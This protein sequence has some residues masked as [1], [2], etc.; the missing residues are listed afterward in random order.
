MPTFK[1]AP[2]KYVQM[3]DHLRD[4]ITRG[5]L[6][7]GDEV[8]SE[9]Q[10]A[11]EWE[12]ARPTATKALDVLRR[13]GLLTGRQ[14]AGTFVTE[15]SALRR[16]A[17]DR[18]VRSR[19]TGRIYLPNE[20]AQILR[21]E[22]SDAPEH[23]AQ[24][25]GLSEG[26]SVVRRQR[27]TL[28]DD[29]PVELSTSWFAGETAEVAPRLLDAERILEG[30]LSYVEAS[31]GRPATVARDR[32]SARLA[33][34]EERHLLRLPDPC[35]VVVTHHTVLD[36]DDLVLDFSESVGPPDTWSVEHEYPLG[37]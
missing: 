20:R 26:S 22:L 6:R 36:A 35:A 33:T 10:L 9:R 11:A 28:R 32:V 5:H 21:A 27:L 30:T 25:L 8:P 18:Y 14:G 24:A 2:P 13:E 1:Q 31:T 17:E 19:Q 4:Q 16:Q 7:P 29:E 12:V 37:R 23:V 3:A 15:P 34:D